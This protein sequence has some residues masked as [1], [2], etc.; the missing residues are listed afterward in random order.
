ME[1][2]SRLGDIFQ[3]VVF[4]GVCWIIVRFTIGKDDPETVRK[5]YDRKDRYRG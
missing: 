4:L 1:I 5:Y 3:L 2:L